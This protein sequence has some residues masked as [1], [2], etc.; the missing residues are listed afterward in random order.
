M[1]CIPPIMTQ[2]LGRLCCDELNNVVGDQSKA[3]APAQSIIIIIYHDEQ[4]NEC[5]AAH[6][7]RRRNHL[8]LFARR[9]RF[10][11]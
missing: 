4:P 10:S 5:S 6:D 7:K 1:K 3:A 8:G 9:R 11:W 2:E